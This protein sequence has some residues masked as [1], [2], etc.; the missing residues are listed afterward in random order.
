[1]NVLSIMEDVV[2]LVSILLVAITAH[3]PRVVHWTPM[4]VLAM[5][6]HYSM[7]H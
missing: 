7:Y 4:V 6:R 1:M 3:V 2:I 5:V